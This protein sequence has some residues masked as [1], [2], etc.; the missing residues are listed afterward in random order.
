VDDKYLAEEFLD[1]LSSLPE[2]IGASDYQYPIVEDKNGDCRFSPSLQK[3]LNETNNA[4]L[5]AWASLERV[6]RLFNSSQ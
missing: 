4:H 6:K 1:L 5:K 3:R 2:N